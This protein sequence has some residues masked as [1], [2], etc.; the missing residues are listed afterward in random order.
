MNSN[1]AEIKLMA[2]QADT[3]DITWVDAVV[4][5]TNNGVPPEIITRLKELW[6]TTKSIGEQVYEV[7]KIIVMKLIQFIL[8]N[9]NMAIGLVLGIGVGSL[10]N[11][12]P[13][14]GTILAPLAMAIGG[15]FGAIAGH[16]LDKI[17]KG[18]MNDLKDSD[19]F[20]DFITMAKEAWKLIVDIF[21]ALKDHF[22]V[23][24]EK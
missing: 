13:W 15:F 4:N 6:E 24:K 21:S 10:I 9:R 23:N 7:G 16:R 5:F 20:T 2:L 11:M 22:S 14:I 1:V 19:I 12:I 17:A 18:D 3:K 8:D